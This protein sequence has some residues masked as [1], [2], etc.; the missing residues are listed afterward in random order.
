MPADNNKLIIEGITEDGKT[1][2]PSDWIDRLCGSVSSYGADRRA[3]HPGRPN[4]YRGPE[5]RQRRVNFLHPQVIDGIKCTI[6][7]KLPVPVTWQESEDLVL[8]I[9]PSGG[10]EEIRTPDL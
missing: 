8:P 2:R 4:G 5:R 6:H 10:A 9:E 1:F 7:Y 3:K